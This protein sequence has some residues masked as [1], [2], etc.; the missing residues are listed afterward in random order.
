MKRLPNEEYYDNWLGVQVLRG[1]QWWG[2]V[3]TFR[4]KETK[5]GN[6]TR[7]SRAQIKGAAVLHENA[8]MPPTLY[9]WPLPSC[10]GLPLADLNG[11]PGDKGARV[12]VPWEQL[13]SHRAEPRR[14]EKEERRG[15]ED[16]QDRA[17]DQSKETGRA[18][19]LSDTLG[20][21]GGTDQALVSVYR[22]GL[23]WG[24]SP[25]RRS[26]ECRRT[27]PQEA[28]YRKIKKILPCCS[29]PK[30]KQL[31]NYKSGYYV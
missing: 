5:R 1:W 29:S 30:D 3:T 14:I 20:C 21:W 2:C 8:N 12:C 25:G 24:P 19:S 31:L 18:E 26:C 11:K 27:K 23:Y 13:P 9:R 6:I 17:P 10:W 4:V 15:T 28:F 7:P 22:L 16:N